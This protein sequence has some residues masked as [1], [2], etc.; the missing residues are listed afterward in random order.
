MPALGQAE[1]VREGS[2]KDPLYPSKGFGEKGKRRETKL[3]AFE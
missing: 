3:T 1:G 2:V